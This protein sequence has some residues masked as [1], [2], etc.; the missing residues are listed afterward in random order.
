MASPQVED[1]Y[2]KIAN[3]LLEHLVEPGINGSEYRLV[4]CLIRKTYG[5]G[6]KTDVISLSQFQR[7]TKMGRKGVVDTIKSLVGKRVLLREGNR[8][9]INKNWEEWVVVKRPPGGQKATRGSGQKA[10]KTSGQKATYK[11]KKESIKEIYAAKAAEEAK[12]FVFDEAVRIME[13]D[14]RRH[15]NIIALYFREKKPNLKTKGQAETAFR[16]HL[17]PAKDLVPFTDDQIL[18]AIPKARDMT[19]QWTLE[20]LVKILT[21]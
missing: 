13:E 12:P 17:R 18:S 1:G 16:R 11:R 7:L 21:K 19:S 6:K 8:Y 2:T 10:T 15:V 14:S 3:E 5:Y 20:T 4:F 9:G